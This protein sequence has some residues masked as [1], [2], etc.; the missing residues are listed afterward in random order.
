MAKIDRVEVKSAG[1]VTVAVNNVIASKEKSGWKLDDVQ[2]KPN[3]LDAVV[4]FRKD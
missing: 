4:T 2:Y 3:G 1:N